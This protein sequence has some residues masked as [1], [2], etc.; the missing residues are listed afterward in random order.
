MIGVGIIGAGWWAGV[1]AQV[2]RT[3]PDVRLVA[4]TGSTDI[5]GFAARWGGRAARSLDELLADPAV[6][7]VLI[8]APHQHHEALAIAAAAAGK[9]ILLEKPMAPTVAACDR[10][11]AAV[12]Q[13]GVRLLVG[14]TMRF[15]RPCLAARDL[16]ASG[17]FGSPRFGSSWLVKLWMEANRRPWHLRPETGGGLLLTAGIHALDRLMFLF[18]RPV[19]AVAAHVETAFHAQAADDAALLLVSFTGGGAGMVSS[20][21][22]RCGAGAVGSE[23]ALDDAVIRVDLTAGVTVGRDEAW[24]A[25]PDSIEPDW[26]IAALR[27]EWREL[28]AAIDGRRAPCFAPQDARA[29]VAVIE[30]AFEASASRAEVPVAGSVAMTS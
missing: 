18:G 23:I 3:L 10:I 1:H 25:V 22:Y 8:A 19:R 24:T 28:I 17:R 2:L 21:G 27:R 13:A 16:I 14:H 9:H 30:A 15:A 7:A 29:V 12:E 4:S 11:I 5:E 26:H 20:I 6:T